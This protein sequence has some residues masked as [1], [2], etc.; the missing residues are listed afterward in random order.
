MILVG[1]WQKLKVQVSDIGGLALCCF[2][3]IKVVL[4]IERLCLSRGK[5]KQQWTAQMRCGFLWVCILWMLNNS[6]C[7]YCSGPGCVP[8]GAMWWVTCI[9]AHSLCG[10]LV[11]MGSAWLPSLGQRP[12]A[13]FL[14]CG[15][16]CLPTSTLKLLSPAF[17]PL[18]HR[19]TILMLILMLWILL[20]LGCTEAVA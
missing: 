16:I 13:D 4:E 9:L 18:F 20:Q 11:L 6:W 10:W 8:W 15:G 19:V 2:C 1:S 17:M 12:L 5:K 3:H 14:L 7:S